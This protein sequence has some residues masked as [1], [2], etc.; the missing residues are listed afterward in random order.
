MLFCFYA[1]ARGGELEILPIDEDTYRLGYSL[2]SLRDL[3]QV[4]LTATTEEGVYF[5]EHLKKL[6]QLI[7]DG[8]HPE[9]G[10]S[11]EQQL[12]LDAVRG[13]VRAF[14]M[15]PLTATLFAPASTPLLNRARLSNRCLQAV[16]RKLSLSVDARSRTIGRVSYAEA[17]DQP[18]R[19]GLRGAAFVQGDVRRPG[20]DPRQTGERRLPR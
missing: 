2:E 1:E 17:G 11:G 12:L 10:Q 14:T 19:G 9:A 20:I 18:A 16:I 6:F 7:H 13:Q 8:F 3:E 5:H 15:R 4:P